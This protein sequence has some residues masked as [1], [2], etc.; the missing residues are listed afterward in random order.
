VG[1]C[2]R[3]IETAAAVSS[4]SSRMK[5]KRKRIRKGPGL[6]RAHRRK[7]TTRIA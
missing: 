6:V 2:T 5:I 3:G 7:R 4:N 1:I